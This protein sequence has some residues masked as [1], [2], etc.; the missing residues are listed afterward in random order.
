MGLRRWTRLL[1]GIVCGAALLLSE[2]RGSWLGIT[3]VCA[4]AVGAS[5]FGLAKTRRLVPA[6]AVLVAT[7][8]GGVL[9]LLF[10]PHSASLASGNGR[11]PIWRFALNQWQ[12]SP[13][14][15][16][17]PH[18]WGDFIA[19]G[20]VP[21]DVGQAHNQFLESLLTLGI[22][23]LALLLAIF[24]CWLLSATRAISA[25]GEWVHIYLLLFV[26]V[27]SLF[28]APLVLGGIDPRTWFLVCAIAALRPASAP[29]ASPVSAR[30]PRVGVAST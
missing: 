4:M 24:A 3:L 18:A 12:G 9:A 26:L 15:G 30:L 25:T 17:G 1:V 16:V 19:T 6:Y 22:V 20:A 5:G 21:A 23:G 29:V 11:A 10:G 2:S 8:L 14:L 13:L 7:V 27:T 28:E